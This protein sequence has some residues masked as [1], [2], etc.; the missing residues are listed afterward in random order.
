MGKTVLITPN[1]AMMVGTTAYMLLK[2]SKYMRCAPVF[3][4]LLKDKCGA[5]LF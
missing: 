1:T 2:A 5:L 4:D 3:W